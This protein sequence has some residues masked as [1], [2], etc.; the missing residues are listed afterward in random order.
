MAKR[1]C[2]SF[3]DWVYEKYLLN[4][5]N[6]RSKYIEGMFVI[7]VNTETGEY[8]GVYNRAIEMGK[9]IRMKDEEIVNLKRQLASVKSLII[10]QEQRREE[11]LEKKR[12]KK[13][14]KFMKSMDWKEREEYLKEH[15]LEE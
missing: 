5:G 11:A 2:I 3:S 1:F 12:I 4:T 9:Q 10:T 8:A 7:G 15:P 6:N 14:K 13:Q